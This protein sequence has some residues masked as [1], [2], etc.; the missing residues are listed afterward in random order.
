MKTRSVTIR[1]LVLTALLAMAHVTMHAQS[2]SSGAQTISL[3]ATLNESISINLSANSVSFNLTAGSAS[4]PGSQGVTATT[5]WISKPGRNVTTY[6]YFTS[7]ASA[8]TDGAGNNIPSSSFEV[9]DNGGA[10]LP[11]TNTVVFGGAG[12]GRQLTSQKITGTNK[13][14]SYTDS[15]LFNINLSTL[16]QLPAG[17]Y[18]GTVTLRAEAN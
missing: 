14:G 16:P 9:S 12:A 4:N 1:L 10:F 5:T 11:L 3:A 2:L 17:T 18:A 8:L 7:A 6:I 13:T 15:M